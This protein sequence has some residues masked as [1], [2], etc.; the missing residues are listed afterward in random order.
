MWEHTRKDFLS[1]YWN[2]GPQSTNGRRLLG[3]GNPMGRDTQP[4]SPVDCQ[5]PEVSDP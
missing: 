5:D 1:N 3:G 4:T 2:Q